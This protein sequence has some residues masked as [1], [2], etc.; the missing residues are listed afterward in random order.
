MLSSDAHEQYATFGVHLLTS[1]QKPCRITEDELRNG[2]VRYRPQK[3]MARP[4]LGHDW[5]I[6]SAEYAYARYLRRPEDLSRVGEVE[7]SGV[8]VIGRRQR[9]CSAEVLSRNRED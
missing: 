6:F 4:K 7:G 3:K 9:R 1:P 8:L 2:Q 5:L